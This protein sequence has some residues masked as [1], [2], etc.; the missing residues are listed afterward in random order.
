MDHA[1][2]ERLGRIERRRDPGQAARRAFDLRGRAAPWSGA[3]SGA[4]DGP[5]AEGAR[6]LNSSTAT[7]TEIERRVGP[8]PAGSTWSGI[9]A[10]IDATK[11]PHEQHC[12]DAEARK[13]TEHCVFGWLRSL[14]VF[15]Q[16]FMSVRALFVLP[17]VGPCRLPG[18]KKPPGMAVFCSFLLERAKGF[19]PSTPTLARLCGVN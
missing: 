1:D 14:S 17:G 18:M 3:L 6:L 19:E 7:K 13:V 4:R 10:V 16:S 2:L 12:A 8:R 11:P 5:A 15:C 9:D